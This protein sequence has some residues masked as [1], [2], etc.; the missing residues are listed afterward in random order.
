MNTQN[1]NDVDLTEVEAQETNGID[2]KDI[3]TKLSGMDRLSDIFVETDNSGYLVGIT[4]ELA[5]NMPDMVA[6]VMFQNNL[7]YHQSYVQSLEDRS[8]PQN[9]HTHRVEFIPETE[10][11]IK[12]S[13][14]AETAEENETVSWN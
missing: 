11:E 6:E 7:V 12:A 8:L 5:S 3:N 9:V 1:I 2:L 14:A 4:V 13:T 10:A